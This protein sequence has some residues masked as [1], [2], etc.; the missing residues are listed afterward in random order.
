MR[1]P[2][3]ARAA[4]TRAYLRH[5]AATDKPIVLGPFRSELGFEVLYWLPFLH[6]AQRVAGIS[7]ERCIALSRGG[8]GHLYPAAK[9]VDLYTLRGVDV[10]RTENQ[11]D[12]ETRKMLKQVRVTG[13]DRDVAREAAG[14][15]H[16]L[17]HPSWMYWLYEGWWENYATVPHIGR[18]ADFAPLPVP[19]LPEGLTLPEKFCA[20]RF[21][22]RPTFPLSDEVKAVILE[23]VAGLAHKAPVVLLN[24]SLFAD[25]HVDL[26]IS[27]PNIITLP[28]VPPEQNF[29]LQ[30]AVLARCKA[31][32]GTYGGVAQWALRYKRPSLSFY[33]TFGG[34]ALAHRTLSELLAIQQGVPF[35]VCDLKAYGLW[36]AA[37]GA[38]PEAVAA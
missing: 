11:V 27:G 14:G 10:V 20:V 19:A 32:V 13:W 33:T 29:L 9:A 24:Q 34:T 25:D 7:P 3:T 26:P 38:I 6:W 1:L 30:A 37:L 16:H 15:P 22:E 2:P 4:I 23:I 21:Y 17:L 35:E 18:H 8:M 12:L 31:F 5:L 28:A 36:K